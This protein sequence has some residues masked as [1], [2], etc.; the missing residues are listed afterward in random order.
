IP[1]TTETEEQY[2]QNG[3]HSS[4]ASRNAL[5]NL[6]FLGTV[7][8]TWEQ[9]EDVNKNLIVYNGQVLD[10]D[11]VNWLLSDTFTEADI[12]KQI[13]QSVDL[14][15]RDVT[16]LLSQ[17][18]E[19]TKLANCLVKTLRV[20]IVDVNSLGC[21]ITD[22]VLYVSL[23]FIVGVVLV[24][25]MLA[26]LFGWVLSWKLGNFRE[27][28][29]EERRKRQKE[30]ERWANDPNSTTTYKRTGFLSTSRFSP[31]Q[32]TPP[33]GTDGVGRHYRARR[34]T[35]SSTGR[36]S[37]EFGDHH[38][39]PGSS[40]V[41]SSS[42]ST[43]SRPESLKG[44]YLNQDDP[45]AINPAFYSSKAP[46]FN[47]SSE[48]DVRYDFR[49]MHTIM[50]VACYSEGINGLRTTLDSLAATDYPQSHKLLLC[51]ADGQITGAGNDKSTP[52]ILLSLMKDFVVPPHEVVAHSYV[53][54]ADGA[55]RHNMAKV[56]A[57]YY[58]YDNEFDPYGRSQVPMITI[59]KTGGPGEED[60]KKPGNRGKRDSQVILMSFL[61]NVI[62]DDR[63]T[64]LEYELFNMIWAVTGVTPDFFE[65]V[66]NVDADTK[67]FPDSLSKMV[68]CMAKD[69]NIMGLCGETKIA[70]KS[71][72][73]VTMIQ[74]FE[75]YISHHMQKAFESIFGGVTCL[76]GCFCMYR[77]KAP[78][79]HGY[80]VPILANSDIV[81]QYAENVVDTL[82]KKNLLLLGEDRYLSTLML[83]TFPK[84]KMVFVPQAV[85]KT[86][87]PDSFSVLKSQRRRWINST[88][89]NLLELVLIPNLCGTFCFSM[90][91]VIFMELV[92]TVVLPAAICFTGFLIII[93]FVQKP[94][95]LI[96]L[97]LLGAVLGLPAVLILMTTRKIVYVFWMA[98]YL[99]SLPIW[100]FVLPVYAYWHFDDFSWGQTRVVKGDG[101][102]EAYG[103][104][105]GE[106]D[107]KQI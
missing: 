12:L 15:G 81:N 48:V 103:W 5:A 43:H 33:A 31:N 14:H 65:V 95:P 67:V 32:S 18:K 53:A 57:G 102:G 40:L 35:N 101:A 13:R 2:T 60:D 6:P 34:N 98:V 30:I 72:T 9:V 62:S 86:I 49:L 29:F 21:V 51:I 74:V 27:V 50:L 59:V 26:M 41:K 105:E 68:A 17:T 84:R 22:I 78:K 106:F 93:S 16:Y 52:D 100:N 73:W 71:D 99:C 87:V 19:T 42:S 45:E 83:R 54:I 82:H 28:T 90:Q 25:F 104:K 107:S 10:L 91:F 23:V 66:L 24:R 20:G 94:I 92:G 4:D 56:Y 97:L 69:P 37:A 38:R 63:M 64:A 8:F 80:W 36:S 75:Y 11:R 77:I 85:C 58:K 3:C 76:P 55:K 79:G 70:N 7:F 44:V 88:V 1:T 61:N 39:V 47:N 96:P 46:S 89:H